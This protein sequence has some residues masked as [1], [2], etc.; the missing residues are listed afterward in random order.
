[1]KKT[2]IPTFI[3]RCLADTC[4]ETYVR[5]ISFLVFTCGVFFSNYEKFFYCSELSEIISKKKEM[6]EKKKEEKETASKKRKQASVN[7]DD[8]VRRDT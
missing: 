5:L 8:E 1:M 3:G 2:C 7:S 4:P 6:K